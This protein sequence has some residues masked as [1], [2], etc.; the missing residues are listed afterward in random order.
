MSDFRSR[1]SI[2]YNVFSGM[3]SVAKASFFVGM[4][5]AV[6]RY[7]MGFHVF[8]EP[9]GALVDPTDKFTFIAMCSLYISGGF[10]C[11]TAAFH[12]EP[13]M[14]ADKSWELIQGITKEYSASITKNAVL[15]MGTALELIAKDRVPSTM[16][17]T[18]SAEKVVLI[19]KFANDALDDVVTRCNN[20]KQRLEKD[21]TL[22][23]GNVE[24]EYVTTE[25]KK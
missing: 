21:M 2:N 4:I 10:V 25:E 14:G 19:Q 16:D 23:S 13:C 15:P 6:V 20:E 22:S 8:T 24:V 9:T 3:I 7:F 11:T 18:N 5:I 17:A 1:F 12:L